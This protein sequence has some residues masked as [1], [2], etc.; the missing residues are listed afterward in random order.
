[1]RGWRNKEKGLVFSL[2]KACVYPL[3]C[4]LL[5]SLVAIAGDGTVYYDMHPEDWCLSWELGKLDLRLWSVL[6]TS[7]MTLLKSSGPFR[8]INDLVCWQH[9]PLR[10]RTFSC[11]TLPALTLHGSSIP[12]L[13]LEKLSVVWLHKL[14][15]SGASFQE[16][17]T[18]LIE[19]L[20][21][22]TPLMSPLPSSL[23]YLVKPNAFKAMPNPKFTK[24]HPHNFSKYFLSFRVIHVYVSFTCSPST[25]ESSTEGSTLLCRTP[26]FLLCRVCW[27]ALNKNNSKFLLNKELH[28]DKCKRTSA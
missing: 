24:K 9:S 10:P 19:Y 15:R 7:W 25:V 26:S 20:T 14:T 22:S 8:S 28:W 23:I 3:D 5:R 18:Q 4:H 13:C 2:S 6:A 11:L 12:K 1:M 27:I 17:L 16:S 21:F